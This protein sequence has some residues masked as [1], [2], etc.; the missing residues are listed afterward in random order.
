MKKERDNAPATAERPAQ[1]N[2]PFFIISAAIVITMIVLMVVFDKATGEIMQTL[3][4]F[5]GNQL[6]WAYLVITFVFFLFLLWLAFS[7]FGRIRFGGPKARPEFKT[8]TWIAMFFCS[9]IGTALMTWATKEW[10]YY[11]QSPPFDMAA[12]SVMATEYALAYPIFHWGPLGW[13][14]Y[15]VLA[16]PI[17]YMYWNRKQESYKFADACVGV[18]GEKNTKGILGCIINFTLIL[19]LIGANGTSL[20]TG[21]P[22][23][24][25]AVCQ[26]LGLTHTFGVD[27]VVVLI[28]TAIFTTS[29]TLGLQ[30]GI[31]VLS[32]INVVAVLALLAFILI[33][34]P[35]S[36]II[37]A[38]VN[39]NGI[40]IQDFVRMAIYTDPIGK[41]GFPQDWTVFYW[42]WYY[43]YAPFMGAFIARVS[44][45]RTF[46]ETIVT[47]LGAGTI[48][49]GMFHGIMGGNAMF[50]QLSGKLDFIKILNEQGDAAAVV[51]SIRQLPFDIII[52]VIFVI[53]GFVF[54]ATTIDSAAYSMAQ[55]SCKEIKE[56][57]EPPRYTRLVWALTMGSIALVVMNIG[58]LVPIKTTSLLV[59]FPIMIFSC[60]AVITLKKWL[61]ED[62]AQIMADIEE[63]KE[64][65]RLALGAKAPA[66]AGK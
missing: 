63:E 45:G 7:K 51:A 1:V 57:E 9:G 3:Y 46:R 42:A 50:Q 30:K 18:I 19:G 59:A 16:F 5:T 62:E 27:I 49:A 44:K 37:N 47:T 52:L 41:T 6:G 64:N 33:V 55:T 58:G 53:C 56:G 34:G 17:G 32:D 21:T 22:M 11:M 66:A 35:T 43:A 28:W 39:S 12:N 23:L 31:K 13:V 65:E 4:N 2:K 25:E 61:K 10:A 36:F 40:M 20:G 26:L 14:I 54:S 48:G 60:F 8:V 38:F 29:V 15:S 24:A